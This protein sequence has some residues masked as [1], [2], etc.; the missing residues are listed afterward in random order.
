MT[1][2]EFIHVDDNVL[3]CKPIS[4]EDIVMAVKLEKEE[5]DEQ[6]EDEL[7]Q[8]VD[9]EIVEITLT[10]AE[11]ISMLHKVRLTVLKYSKCSVDFQSVDTLYLPSQ[12]LPCHLL[13]RQRLSAMLTF[14]FLKTSGFVT[15][16]NFV[17]CSVWFLCAVYGLQ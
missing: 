16:Q 9:D 15:V 7:D 14:A 11:A 5:N 8:P 3:T 6:D 1:T 10:P 12:T 2:D 13:I 4:D 17:T